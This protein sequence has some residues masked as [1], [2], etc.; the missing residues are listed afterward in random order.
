MSGQMKNE[1]EECGMGNA[2]EHTEDDMD[3]TLWTS[4]N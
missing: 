4:E 3:G 1:G 2:T